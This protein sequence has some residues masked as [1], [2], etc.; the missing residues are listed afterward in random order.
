MVPCVVVVVGGRVC[1]STCLR[2]CFGVGCASD[3]CRCGLLPRREFSKS[4]EGGGGCRGVI[5]TGTH[6]LEPK[7]YRPTTVIPYYSSKYTGKRYYYCSSETYCRPQVFP[8][9]GAVVVQSSSGPIRVYPPLL[10]WRI[11]RS[12]VGFDILAQCF[13]CCCCSCGVVGCVT[14]GGVGLYFRCSCAEGK[15]GGVVGKV[16]DC[17][18]FQYEHTKYIRMNFVPIFLRLSLG[19]RGGI[20]SASARRATTT[21]TF[22]GIAVVLVFC[23]CR[24]ILHT[25][26]T[27]HTCHTYILLYSSRNCV[28]GSSPW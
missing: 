20:E 23:C 5:T 1:V 16:R 21:A 27:Y 6:L 11:Y 26:Y 25:Y 14:S 8:P 2:G 10:R 4:V 7:W 28:P 9:R 15:R 13:C 18:G 3:C 12:P 19:S 24:T 22:L 17:C